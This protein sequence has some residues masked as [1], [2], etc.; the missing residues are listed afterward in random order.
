[1]AQAKCKIFLYHL[2]KS[3]KSKS[4]EVG[5]KFNP[6]GGMKV[7]GKYYGDKVCTKSTKCA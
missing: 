2:L 3:P 4:E 5:A 1:M 7:D 6:E